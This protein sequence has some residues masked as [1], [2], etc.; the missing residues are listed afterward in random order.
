MSPGR[1]AV[2]WTI[3]SA[4]GALAAIGL[5]SGTGSGEPLALAG[6]A[7]M[8]LVALAG[9]AVLARVVLLTE[10]QRRHR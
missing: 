2:Y 3:V 7:A 8:A 10:R 5:V 4:A 6:G 9:V 1:F